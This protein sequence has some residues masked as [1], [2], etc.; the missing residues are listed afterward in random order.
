MIRLAGML[1]SAVDRELPPVEVI[2]PLCAAVALV[3]LFVALDF[4]G[5]PR[6]LHERLG[7]TSG[8]GFSSSFE[9][10]RIIGWIL[11]VG[12]ILGIA[13]TIL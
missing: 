10:Q 2:I 11:V 7:G 13:G 6:R 8:K 3:G 5:V 12:A 9:F 4:K 1:T